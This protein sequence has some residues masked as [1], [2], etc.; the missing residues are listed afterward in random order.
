MRWQGY[1]AS[2]RRPLPLRTARHRVRSY[3]YIQT[4]RDLP[5]QAAACL[6]L[7]ERAWEPFA[8]TLFGVPVLPSALCFFSGQDDEDAEEVQEQLRRE[9]GAVSVQN[10]QKEYQIDTAELQ[11]KVRWPSF[12]DWVRA[13]H[14]WQA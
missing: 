9:W 2:S 11:S 13:T 10:E 5:V 6:H 8:R 3:T 4:L 1:Q 14:G 12:C 7:R